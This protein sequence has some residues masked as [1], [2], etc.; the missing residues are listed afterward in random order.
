MILVSSC[1]IHWGQVL[2]REWR[3]FWSSADRWCSNYI[4]V[5]SNFIAY[6]GMSYI[7]GLTLLLEV[8][9]IWASEAQFLGPFE[10]QNM[11]WFWSLVIFSKSF[12]MV[13]LGLLI[14]LSYFYRR[15]YRP[16]TPNFL[17]T[18]GPEIDHNSSLQSFSQK[19]STGF[20]PFLFYMLIWNTFRCISMMCPKGPISGPRV[21]VAAELV[22]PSGF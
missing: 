1:P 11:W 6:S 22:R 15:E 4:W 7:R 8:W 21:K 10:P 16:Q 14:N 2:S 13:S 3:C 19:F 20:T 9:R 5:T 17:V 18:L 12:L